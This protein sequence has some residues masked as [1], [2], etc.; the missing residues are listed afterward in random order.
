MKWWSFLL[1]PTIYLLSS[2]PAVIIG[3]SLFSVL[4]LY[5]T[6]AGRYQWLS[7]NA[8]N[9][10]IFIPNEYYQVGLI[11]GLIIAFLG[12]GCWIIFTISDK[13]FISN[14]RL[15][16]LALNSVAL[17]PFLLPKMHDRYFYPADVFS[18]IAALFIPDLWFVPILFQVVSGLAYTVYLLDAPVLFVKIAS[19]VNTILIAFLIYYQFSRKEP[20]QEI[21]KT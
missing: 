8:P 16:L 21:I 6:Q 9:L 2:L 5:L 13:K 1:I 19:I 7:G 17:T 10:Y 3:R 4:S 12:V 18:I 11:T 20:F 14:E 15:I